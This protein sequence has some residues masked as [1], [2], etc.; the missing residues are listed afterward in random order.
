MPKTYIFA[1][2]RLGPAE[3][4]LPR[5]CTVFDFPVVFRGTARQC[6]AYTRAN[7]YGQFRRDNSLFGGYFVNAQGDC[8]LPT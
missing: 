4:A 3:L 8:L 5:D 2:R 7:G 6:E 1:L